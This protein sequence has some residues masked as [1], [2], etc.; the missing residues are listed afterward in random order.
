M[1]DNWLQF[2]PTDPEFRPS[3]EAAERARR[4]LATFVPQADEVNVEFNDS[5]AFYDAGGNWS[6]VY[7]PACGI[8]AEAWWVAAMDAAYASAFGD[9]YSRAPCC[10]ARIS[11]NEMYYPW[12]VAFGRFMIEAMN[13]N[14]RGLALDQ[15][16]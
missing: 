1:S 6:G 7:C 9:L 3:P 16:R 15:V 5:V 11:L 14:V 8:D 2:V 13:P 10:G 12:P 4:L